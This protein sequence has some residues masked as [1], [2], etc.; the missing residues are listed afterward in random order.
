M[1]GNSRKNSNIPVGLRI[2]ADELEVLDHMTQR[3]LLAQVRQG[4]GAALLLNEATCAPEARRSF[5]AQ[6]RV[7][8]RATN[9][10]ISSNMRLVISVVANS[11]R[12]SPWLDRDD[13][14]QEGVRGLTRA[15]EKFDLDRGTMLS[16][17]AT[18][19]I[20]QSVQRAVMNG[21]LVRIPVHVQDGTASAATKACAR[22]FDEIM[23]IEGMA[24]E[25]L[26]VESEFAAG[27]GPD[28]CSEAGLELGP[29]ESDIDDYINEQACH[30]MVSSVLAHLD[31]REALVLSRR[32]GL[33]D[34]EPQ[35]LEQ[36]GQHLGVTR[37]RVRQIEKGALEKSRRL[38]EHAW[39]A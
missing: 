19:W 9:R 27:C 32:C 13:L 16:T 29:V 12:R 20:R 15:I 3:R 6:V 7:G 36:I 35:T 30:A 37:E 17:Y 14:I 10:L 24:D 26:A 22:R 21:G 39:T 18:Q 25:L 4:Q 28:E 34:G 1:N 38:L 2:H 31:D 11:R 5:E 33:E 23:S 8:R